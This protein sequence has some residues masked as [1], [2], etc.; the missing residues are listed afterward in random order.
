[1]AKKNSSSTTESKVTSSQSS[2]T[3]APN[4]ES[5]Q[6][7]SASSV[8]FTNEQVQT[9]LDNQNQKH[10]E[11]KKQWGSAYKELQEL[12]DKQNKERNEKIKKQ[13]DKIERLENRIQ[14]STSNSFAILS[15]FATVFIFISLNVNIFQEITSASTAV[16]FMFIIALACCFIISVPLL[17]LFSLNGHSFKNWKFILWVFVLSIVFLLATWLVTFFS[18][19]ELKA[20]INPATTNQISTEKTTE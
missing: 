5:E 13:D 8:T 20:K 7:Q 15:I 12:F 2:V 10:E 3:S 18:N 17:V 9:L 11:E 4:S 6:T 19:F 16:F 14:N 1:M